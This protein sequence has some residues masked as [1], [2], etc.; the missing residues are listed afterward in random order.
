MYIGSKYRL[1][2]Y[3]ICNNRYRYRPWK[4]HIGRPLISTLSFNESQRSRRLG[5][6][7]LYQP[8]WSDPHLTSLKY[9]QQ[10]KVK[11]VFVIFLKNNIGIFEQW[12][13]S[14]T[15][16]LREKAYQTTRDQ[17]GSHRRDQK[18]LHLCAMSLSKTNSR[19]WLQQKDNIWFNE[20]FFQSGYCNKSGQVIHRGH[21]LLKK[22][23]KN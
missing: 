17:F 5:R 7:H 18:P 8:G 14:I 1:S 12:Y 4:T 13:S 19:K 11:D 9:F 23:Y 3:L 16:S 2:V 21:E 15:V 20:S 22:G 10:K 6:S